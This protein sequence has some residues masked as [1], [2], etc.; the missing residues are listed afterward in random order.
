MRDPDDFRKLLFN[1]FGKIRKLPEFILN[2]TIIL[3]QEVSWSLRVF[4]L[5]VRYRMA[6]QS[7]D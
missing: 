4:Y 2:S 7:A 6:N 3:F 5:K 1:F